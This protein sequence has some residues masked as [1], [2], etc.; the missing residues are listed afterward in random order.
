[1]VQRFRCATVMIM[2][3]Q[4][5]GDYEGEMRSDPEG[6]W[7]MLSTYQNETARLRSEI[8]RLKKHVTALQEQR[9][10]LWTN[11]YNIES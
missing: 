1:M 11:L 9:D 4:E 2:H 6:D 5:S 3:G 8:A 10:S 7:V